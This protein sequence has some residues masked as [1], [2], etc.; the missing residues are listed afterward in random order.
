M[1][2]SYVNLKYSR[3]EDTTEARLQNAQS[4]DLPVFRSVRVYR[5]QMLQRLCVK[6][7]S[8]NDVSSDS[9]M[10][11]SVAILDLL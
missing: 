10:C 5:Q 8:L 1:T 11:I 6:H 7:T 4:I 9:A 2:Y 3:E